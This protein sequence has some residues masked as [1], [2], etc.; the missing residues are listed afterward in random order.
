LNEVRK[1]KG[2]KVEKRRTYKKIQR[3][4]T[5][6]GGVVQEGKRVNSLDAIENCMNPF[7]A[8]KILRF[9]LNATR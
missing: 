7:S 2:E 6:N 9:P 1:N 5:K 3:E 8:I 4:G